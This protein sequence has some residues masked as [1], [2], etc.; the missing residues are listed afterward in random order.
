M[1]V[2][3]GKCIRRL[4]I[5]S[6]WAWRKRNIIATIAVILT[7]LLFTALFT[8]VMSINA[9]YQTYQ[10]RQLGG[11]SHGTFKEVTEQQAADI[12]AHRL[13]KET[14]VRIVVGTTAEGVFAKTP[15]EI[16][17]MDENCTR[18]S[19]ALPTT[20]QIPISGKRSRWTQ[21]RWIYWV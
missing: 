13:V 3:N 6:L 11:Y 17:Y 21:K 5:R 19:Y 16:S 4:S 18:W 20:G 2:K 14:G 15:A 10:F 8:V 7:T 12:H 1:R 9:S